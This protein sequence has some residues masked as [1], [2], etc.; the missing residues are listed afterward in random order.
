MFTWIC[1][2]YGLCLCLVLTAC[3]QTD[4]S[5]FASLGMGRAQPQRAV[6]TAAELAD[7]Q[8]VL[9]PPDG[10]CIDRRSLRQAFALIARCDT[11]GGKQNVPAEPL[12]VI[13]VSVAQSAD[14]EARLSTVLDALVPSDAEVLERVQADDLA[15]LRL[16]GP[17][18]EGADPRQWRGTTRVGRNLLG[19]TLYA[20]VGGRAAGASGGRLV[21]VLAA[22]TRQASDGLSVSASAQ[23]VRQ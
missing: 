16:R 1:K 17:A 6:L 4:G 10:F 21:R 9:S 19:F 2:P 15:L 5:P 3:S 18:P 11:L 7:G 12:A 23:T 13:L 8:L 20:P 22:R 14:Q